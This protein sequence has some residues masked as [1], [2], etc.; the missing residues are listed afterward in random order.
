MTSFAKLE[1]VQVRSWIM[2][3][4]AL[5]SGL[6]FE[7]ATET[8]GA[9]VAGLAGAVLAIIQGFVTRPAVTPNAKVVVSVANPDR[10]QTTAIEAGEAVV[11]ASR[12]ELVVAAAVASGKD[13]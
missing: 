2:A 9:L 12:S 10:P 4:V 7:W 5:V 8:N 11:P 6:G 3:A 1:P 13:E